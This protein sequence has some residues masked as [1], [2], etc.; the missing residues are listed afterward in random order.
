MRHIEVPV[1]SGLSPA[2]SARCSTCTGQ[3]RDSVVVNACLVFTVG[4]YTGKVYFSMVSASSKD[5]SDSFLGMAERGSELYAL[6]M[7]HLLDICGEMSG[8]ML[9]ASDLPPSSAYQV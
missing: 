9:V 4:R 6:A 2:V 5:E 3:I 1:P 8:R 7:E